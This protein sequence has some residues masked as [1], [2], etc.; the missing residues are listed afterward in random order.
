MR[1]LWELGGHRLH[2]VTAP[3]LWASVP[4]EPVSTKRPISMFCFLYFQLTWK[5]NFSPLKGNA[6]EI[7]FSPS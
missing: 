3:P 1:L 2:L 4:P 7:F 5:G 6:L